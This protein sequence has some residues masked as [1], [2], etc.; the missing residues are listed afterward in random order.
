MAGPPDTPHAVMNLRTQLAKVSSATIGQFLSFDVP[1]KQLDGIQVGS[2]AWQ[3]FDCQPA[4]LPMQVVSHL[5]ALVRW[6]AIPDQRGLLAPQ[7]APEV[8]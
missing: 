5:P 8:F 4:A 6:Q 1:P 2:V 7:L 3:P